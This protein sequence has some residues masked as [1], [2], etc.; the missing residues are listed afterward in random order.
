MNSQPTPSSHTKKDTF[1]DRIVGYLNFYRL[2]LIFFTITPLTFSGIFY[3]SNGRYKISYVDSLFNC[4]SAMM[5][6]GLATINLSQ[7][8]GF[9]QALLFVLM[10]I[11][12]PVV[13]SWFTVYM[14][15][16]ER[17]FARKFEKMLELAATK[18]AADIIKKDI[19]ERK[20]WP[21][22]FTASLTGKKLK[23][24]GKDKDVEEAKKGQKNYLRKLR[25]DMIRRMDDAPKLINPSGW[26]SEGPA[27]SRE[28]SDGSTTG[29][30]LKKEVAIRPNINI[31]SDESSD[32]SHQAVR[33]P[34]VIDFVDVDRRKR[35]LSDPGRSSRPNSP[36]STEMQR[37]ETVADP[38]SSPPT[39]PK[40]FQ[41]TQT[42]EF[43]PTPRR[44]SRLSE[45]TPAHVTLHEIPGR[46]LSVPEFRHSRTMSQAP[47]GGTSLHTH[48]THH[49]HHSVLPENSMTRGFGGFPSPFALI[50]VLVSRMFPSVKHTLTRTVT[51]P[52]TVSL[53]PSGV[54]AEPGKKQVPYISFDAVVGRNSAFQ[55]LTSDQLEEIGGVEYRALN[56]LLWIVPLYHFG[57]HLVAFAIIAPYMSL[58][59]WV[60]VF[61]DEI[62]PVNFVWFSAFQI[63]SG[64]TNTGTSLVDESMLPFQ[65]AYPMIVTMIFLILAGNTCFPIFLRFMIWFLSKCC[66][67]ASRMHETLRF[68]LDHPRRCFIYLFPS[69]QTWFLLTVV[70]GLT[71]TDWVSFLVLD[72]RN[73]A[74]SSIPLGVRVLDGFMQ[75][76]AV[77]S[78]GFV[79]VPLASLAPAVQVMY[80]FMMYISIY[81]IA[82]SV[83]ST[84]VY[85]EQSLGIFHRDDTSE[86]EKAFQAAGPRMNVWSRY[87]AMHA[88][89]QLAFG[90]Y[91]ICHLTSTIL[92]FLSLDMWWIALSLF[93]ICIIEKNNIQN[94]DNFSWFTI[95]RI[96]FELV[97]AYGT[98][99]LSL[100]IPTENYSFAGAMHTLSKL[101][102]CLVML[103]G[104]HR[105]LPVAID[106]AVLL[107]NEFEKT[108]EEISAGTIFTGNEESGAQTFPQSLSLNNHN[109]DIRQRSSH[110]ISTRL[111]PTPENEYQSDRER[112]FTEEHSPGQE[113]P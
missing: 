9:Q 12:S 28:Q 29:P 80:V 25:P 40:R 30:H 46:L 4:V 44:P 90:K 69:H 84:N 43:A 76:I 5:V 17:F 109:S 33:E 75:A 78:A 45:T 99:G 98:V 27:P 97:S 100:G 8:T 79:I 68:L 82:M 32:S 51:I 15:R 59:R 108:G 18:K 89:Q 1:F 2:H 103:R 3:A 106:R 39:S 53:T 14:R 95:F 10:C 66:R 19:K 111:S 36:T 104:R 22:R 112:N 58:G 24:V 73:P 16:Y 102:I 23:V 34:V 86:D 6:C 85:E 101:I 42:V 60:P 61:Q 71:F 7:L 48:P 20:P 105:G 41:R 26:V 92:T 94:P 35:R 56:A 31:E 38:N 83:R 63:V 87:L 81:P 113:E 52:A 21:H 64:Y 55:L 47:S 13:V 77:R 72:L 96:I 37:S 110:R 88:K 91:P 50:S 54:G 74:I 107:P 67:G 65:E 62:R 70:L 49:S 93:L 11:G 57:I